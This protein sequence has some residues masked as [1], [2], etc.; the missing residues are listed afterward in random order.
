[1]WQV[2][3]VGDNCTDY[4]EVVMFQSQANQQRNVNEARAFPG[5]LS[6]ALNW[7]EIE[8]ALGMIAGAVGHAGRFP[9]LVMLKTIMLQHCYRLSD[10][11]CGEL[12]AD[13]ISWRHFVGLGIQDDVPD[14]D[15]LRTFRS[16]LIDTGLHVLILELCSRQL[17]QKGFEL[18]RGIMAEPGLIWRESYGTDLAGNGRPMPSALKPNSDSRRGR[19][20]ANLFFFAPY[21]SDG[22]LGKV[23]NTYMKLVPRDDDWVCFVDRDVVFL[24]LDYGNQIADIVSAHPHIGLFTTLNNRICTRSQV[25]GGT[26]TDDLNI[27]H[28]REIAVRLQAQHQ[29]EVEIIDPPISGSLMVLRKRVWKSVGF[30]ENE[31]LALV[32]GEFSRRLASKGFAI[33]LMKGLYVFSLP[34]AQRKRD[35][36]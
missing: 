15:S 35:C 32:D 13:R 25:H 2:K 7:R 28:H 36:G 30:S 3:S 34:P 8:S 14:E 19:R 4:G 18:K 16:Q 11:Q 23:Y 29:R 12:L 10:V 5:Q 20:K 21:V 17:R 1:M 27:L 6:R 24:T 9:S 22:N 31:R 33:G 26:A